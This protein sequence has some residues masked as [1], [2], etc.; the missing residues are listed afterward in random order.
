M[1]ESAKEIGPGVPTDV[2]MVVAR[3]LVVIEELG[4][5][6]VLGEKYQNLVAQHGL[7]TD[8]DDAEGAQSALVDIHH[9]IT[10]PN[11]VD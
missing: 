2:V 3:L 7:A 5:A 9:W 1:P 11:A 6:H 4:C 10:F 8:H